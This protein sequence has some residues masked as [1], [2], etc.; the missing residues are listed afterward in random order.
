HITFKD[1]EL[2]K[3]LNFIGAKLRTDLGYDDYGKSDIKKEEFKQ[4]L[5]EI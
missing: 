3:D 2:L 4:D 1:D 5:K